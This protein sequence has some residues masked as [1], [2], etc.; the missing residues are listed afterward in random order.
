MKD[1]PTLPT[2][3]TKILELTE[4]DHSSA[5]EIEKYV[6]SD[7]A[8]STKL[9]RVVNSPYFGLAGQISSVSQ[10]VVILG[11]NQVRN[12]TLSISASSMFGAKTPR[13]REIRLSLWQQAFGA[14]A[15]AQAIARKKR[16]NPKDQET[17]FVAGLLLNVGALFMLSEFPMQYTNFVYSRLDQGVPIVELERSALKFDHAE[18]GMEL[19][20]FWRLPENLTLLIGRHE[21]P[22]D[23]EPVPI[24]YALHAADR[25]SLAPYDAALN[26]GGAPII[27]PI[28]EE[29][30]GFDEQD[31]LWVQGEVAQKFQAAAE[32]LGV[33]Q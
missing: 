2:V 20:K 21:G 30:L 13:A 18:V 19:A 17:V 1:L 33:F 32:A 10:A 6:G 9:L 3:I 27:E 31:I 23:G 8:I 22:F 28:V 5:L 24:L 14:A 16:L 29:W 25:I 26:E 7:Q 15:A 4:D 12:L 11:L